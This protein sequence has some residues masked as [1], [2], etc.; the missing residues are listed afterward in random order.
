[1]AQDFGDDVGD[2]LIR[3]FSRGFNK[4]LYD[5]MSEY[6]K[7]WYREKNEKDGMSKKDA[8][9][10]AEVMA[11]RPHVCVPFGNATDASYFAQVV[12]ENGTYAAAMTDDKGNGY[13]QFAKDDFE[14]VK[15]CIPQFS[16][17]MTTLKNEEIANILDNGNPVTEEM[18]KGLT[19]IDE[20]PDL[21]KAINEEPDTHD[22]TLFPVQ[23]QMNGKNEMLTF[24]E[25][26]TMGL[27][28]DEQVF[29]SGY[30]ADALKKMVDR[31]IGEDFTVLSVG[32]PYQVKAR[33]VEK[34][35]PAVETPERVMMAAQVT[36]I[37]TQKASVIRFL[38]PASSAVTSMTLRNYSPR[39]MSVLW[40]ARAAS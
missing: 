14:Q 34:D 6:A 39:K 2:I 35:S 9:A 12:R 24:S 15:Q 16:E 28:I 31:D 21:P 20:L 13:V 10:Q 30:S 32:V 26:D 29:F 4:V 36:C 3:A 27:D 25:Q 11:S 38:Q 19:R 40:K 18:F 37:T 22:V 23:V 8:D 1:M 17:V 33:E 5:L 7:T